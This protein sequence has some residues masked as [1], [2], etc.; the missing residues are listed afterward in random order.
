MCHILPGFL[1]FP[2]LANYIIES[3]AR[4]NLGRKIKLTE[5]N[6]FES[7]R[8]NLS[9]KDM[10]IRLFIVQREDIPITAVL[11]ACRPIS[12]QRAREGSL[13]GDTACQNH[14]CD[15]QSKG[16]QLRNDSVL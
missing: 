1:L 13:C 10:S 12:T 11:K 7:L 16:E 4:Q 15:F 5:Q 9:I 6:L 2:S 8:Q 3:R 14:F